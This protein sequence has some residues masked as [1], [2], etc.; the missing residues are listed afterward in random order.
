MKTKEGMIFPSTLCSCGHPCSAHYGWD[1][2]RPRA[3]SQCG[4]EKFETENEAVEMCSRMI[5]NE[6]GKNEM[7]RLWL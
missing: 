4:C 2:G 1:N 7:P 3:C 6:E 5:Q